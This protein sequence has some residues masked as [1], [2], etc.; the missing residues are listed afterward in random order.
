MANYSVIF[1]EKEDGTKPAE[2]Y[3]KSISPKMVARIY[4]TVALLEE[5]GNQARMPRSESL[6]DG[7]FQIRAQQE[8]NISRV[9]YFFAV[10]KTIVLTNGFTKK[11][12]KTPP[13]EIELAKKYK[14]DYEQREAK[15]RENI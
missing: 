5:Y 8:G 10:G 12:P 9:L 3:L 6:R 13:G 4:S 11:T 2:D 14:A 7:I 15:R 1:Y